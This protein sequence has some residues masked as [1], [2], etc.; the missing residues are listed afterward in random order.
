M[1]KFAKLLKVFS[2]EQ[3]VAGLSLDIRGFK[4]NIQYR[5]E[6]NSLK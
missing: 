1:L 2:G 4:K 5:K 6:Q 3:Y